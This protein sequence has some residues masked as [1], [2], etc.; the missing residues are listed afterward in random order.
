MKTTKAVTGKEAVKYILEGVNAIYEPV[1]RTLGPKGKNALLYGTFGGNPRITNDGVTIA[2][3]IEPKNEFVQLVAQSFKEACKRTN[4]RA[5][6]ATTTTTVIAGHAVN[7]IFSTLNAGG[8]GGGSQDVVALRRWLLD[9]GKKVVEE[10]RK[11][12]VKCES[13]S[14]LEKVAIVSV[15]D[16]TLG[17]LIASIVWEVGT[18][19]FVDVTEGFKTE[20]EH[21][22]IKGM[23]FPAKVAAKAFVNNPA[24]YEMVITDAPVLV[25]NYTA[26]NAVEVGEMCN[27]LIQESGVRKFAILAPSFSEQVLVEFVRAA[28]NNVFIFPVKVPSLRTEQ[29]EDVCAYLGAHFINKDAGRTWRSVLVGDLGFVERLIV[30]DIDA[31][32]DAVA[33]GG[34]G[35]KTDAVKERVEM[36]RKAVEETRVASHK[37]LLERRI[38]SLSSAV[39]VIRVGSMSDAETKYLKLKVDDAV[40]ACRGALEEGYVCGG[41]LCLKGIAEAM[42]DSP[43]ADSLRAPYQQIMANAGVTEMEI[44]DEVI[45]N[46]KAVRLA[47]EHAVSVVAHLITTDTL[48]A[49]ERDRSPV[50]GYDAIAAALERKNRMWAKR[51]GLLLEGNTE[52]EA[53]YD[54]MLRGEE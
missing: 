34:K 33:T 4:E 14:D 15:E 27:R 43:L 46:A 5:G 54:R 40:Y 53:A 12:A 10:V 32:E 6:D 16:E 17:K 9:D 21:E 29:F 52:S 50:E 48:V 18:D 24:R 7:K 36:L 51:E 38:A 49:E 45:D 1:R 41:G 19:G 3:C 8:I 13:L 20:I 22:I 2:E 37:K 26:D 30:K 25:T 44:G 28:K 31:R 23:R 39:A 42:P 11:Q 47:V 35:S